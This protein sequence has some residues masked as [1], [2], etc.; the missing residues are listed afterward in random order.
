MTKV[1]EGKEE[2]KK[3]RKKG[4]RGEQGRGEGEKRG[5]VVD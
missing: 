5:R 3:L 2:K 4:E 1:G